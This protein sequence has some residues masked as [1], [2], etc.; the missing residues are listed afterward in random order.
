LNFK[1][2]LH[3]KMIPPRL[4][5]S[6]RQLASIINATYKKVYTSTRG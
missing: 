3:M 1:A 2:A 6:T 4:P 5:K